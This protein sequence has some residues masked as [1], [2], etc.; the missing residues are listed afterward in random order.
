MYNFAACTVSTNLHCER[1]CHVE[2]YCK[3]H[4]LLQTTQQHQ[5]SYLFTRLLYY[6]TQRAVTYIAGKA[7]RVEQSNDAGKVHEA[8]SLRKVMLQFF[9]LTMF[10]TSRNGIVK[11][12]KATRASVDD[13]ITKGL[14][15]IIK[16]VLV[17]GMFT[18]Y[19]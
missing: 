12:M 8:R 16:H 19:S 5:P 18:W 9:H 17:G 3:Q 7:A 15:H 6:P 4:S 1:L 13:A 14:L 11:L 2:S 10:H